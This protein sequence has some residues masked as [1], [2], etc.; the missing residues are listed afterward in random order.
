MK[1][2]CKEVQYKI[3]N[4]IMSYYSPVDM[5]ADAKAVLGMPETPTIYHAIAYMVQGGDFL[6]Y[7]AD[8][9]DFL[10]SLGIN[11]TNKEYNDQ[12]S[13]DLYKHLI[14]L[15]G[16]KILKKGKLI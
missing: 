10:N 14:A 12:K 3:I 2:N 8:V 5:L 1:T 16:E 11:P 4:H 15:N 7:H 6:I 13:W 9:K